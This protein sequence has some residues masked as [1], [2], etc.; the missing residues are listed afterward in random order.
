MPVM[1]LKTVDLP[2]PL[3]PMRLT[4]AAALDGQ[5]QILDGGKTAEV[6]AHGR[7][8]EERH[9]KFASGNALSAWSAC[10]SARRVALGMRPSG[11]KSMTSTRMMP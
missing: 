2:A 8:L 1:R 4:I 7:Q 11:R 5:R 3:G 10:S 9:Q 6:L